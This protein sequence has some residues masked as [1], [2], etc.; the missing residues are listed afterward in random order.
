MTEPT[1]RE[2]GVTGESVVITVAGA[3]TAALRDHFD[4]VEVTVGRSVT[5]LRVRSADPSV[6]H[7]MIRRIEGLG[8]ELLD[9]QRECSS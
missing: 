5:H 7:G 1:E 8:L 9:V 4:D 3:L 6:V 2:P